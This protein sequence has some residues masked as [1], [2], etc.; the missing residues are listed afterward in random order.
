MGRKVDLSKY[1]E[2]EDDATF[3]DLEIENVEIQVQDEAKMDP[4]VR[5]VFE[6][7][8]H[9]ICYSMLLFR[10]LLSIFHLKMRQTALSSM[11]VSDKSK[12]RLNK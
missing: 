11:L 3:G 4:Q 9:Q 6:L 12:I 1:V 10:S 8:Y 2:T 5:T 7:M